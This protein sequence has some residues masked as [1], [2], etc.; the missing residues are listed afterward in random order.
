MARELQFFERVKAKLRGSRDAYSDLIRSI[1]L[2]NQDLVSKSE[3][4]S[5][6][7]DVLGKFPELMVRVSLVLR[8]GRECEDRSWGLSLMSQLLRRSPI[9]PVPGWLQ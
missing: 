6:V 3:L 9:P 2:Y 8:E 4:M 7:S 5:L 1:H